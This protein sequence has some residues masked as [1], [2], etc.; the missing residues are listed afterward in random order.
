MKPARH[1]RAGGNLYKSSLFFVSPVFAQQPLEGYYNPG[2][3]LGGSSAQLGQF[4]TPIITNVLIASGV[5]ALFVMIFAAFN[6]ITGGGDKNKIAQAQNMLNYG[7][8][9][10]IL[11][12]TAYVITRIIG[13]LVGFDFLNQNI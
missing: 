10:L 1:S 6:Y 9:G 4:L 11:V 3:A 8:L 5:F 2:R 12:V 13:A 7:I